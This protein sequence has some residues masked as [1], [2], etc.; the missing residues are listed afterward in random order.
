MDEGWGIGER[1][2]SWGVK[3]EGWGGGLRAKGWGLSGEWWG[4]VVRAEV[5]GW[6]LRV[7]DRVVSGEGWGV[8]GEGWGVKNPFFSQL[9]SRNFSAKCESNYPF[10]DLFER[11]LQGDVFTRNFNGTL[12]PLLTVLIIKICTRTF[13]IIPDHTWKTIQPGEYQD[14]VIRVQNKIPLPR[15]LTILYSCIF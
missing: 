10:N 2:E 13:P 9:R 14:A 4:L 6:E 3:A 12:M 15:L 5:E 7:E 11:V 8:S 1:T